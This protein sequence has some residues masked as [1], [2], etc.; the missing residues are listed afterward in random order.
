MI[1]SIVVLA[2]ITGQ[3]LAEL[4]ISNRNTRKLLARGAFETGAG[5]Y[6]L[7]IALHATWLAG[8]WWLAWD[9]PINLGWLSLVIVLQGLRVWVMRT[10]GD[11]WTARIIVLPGAPLI[12]S[13]P[14][15]FLS[16]P[17]YL[18]VAVEVAALPLAFGLQGF[19]LVFS[20]LNAAV[21]W[22]RIQAEAKALKQNA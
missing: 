17:N 19:A 8:L 1:V 14:Y 15:R 16:H 6:P 3:R 12:T 10:L 18:I 11:R 9:R 2:L 13:G 7:I 4:A 5:H 20:G 22:I 21:L